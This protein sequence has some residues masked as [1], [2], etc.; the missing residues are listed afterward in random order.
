MKLR[1]KNSYIA[2]IAC[3]IVNLC[4][5]SI[6]S[7]SVFSQA[8]AEY[9]NE[10]YGLSL[11]PGDL[12][13][14][15]TIANCVGPITMIA[16]GWINDRFGPRSVITVGG[17]MF[18]GAMFAAGFAKSVAYLCATFGIIG[19]LG[20]GMAYGSAISTA[21]RLFPEKRGLMGGITTAAYGISS[22]I[23]PPIVSSIV[24]VSSAPF[25]F[26][27]TG[28]AFLVIIVIAAMF[29]VGIEK[30][31][32]PSS[33][34]A[35]KSGDKDW[36]EML[37]MPIFYVMMLL[38]I[39]GAFSGMMVISQ[40][41][42]IAV[43]MMG[44]SP[45]SAA[46]TVSVLALFN[47][48][49][50]IAAGSLSDRIGRIGTLRLACAATAF[51]ELCLLMSVRYGLFLFYTGI[52]I[53]GLSF[54]AFMGVYPGFTSDR[55]GLKNNSVNY[56]IMCIGFAFAGYIGPRIAKGAYDATG[57]YRNAFVYACV[58][59]VCGIILTFI[60]DLILRKAEIKC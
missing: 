30:N 24:S 4:L 16:G 57:S 27:V 35:A 31:D 3:L 9:L 37:R 22:V 28:A 25:A 29:L 12:A 15:Y 8:M 10:V 20:L 36:R 46:I 60:Y 14:V 19:G 17:I 18:G 54:G 41:S 53:A 21:I 13:I 33:K 51:S 43:T 44:L 2:L 1:I 39:C 40:A 34:A 58:F 42:P 6:Y 38:L 47:T 56:G 7:W 50:R 5:G 11:N 23:V 49:G 32:S 48:V 26:K 55:F 45:A 52:S 59:S